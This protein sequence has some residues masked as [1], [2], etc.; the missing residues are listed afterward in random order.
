[1]TVIVIITNLMTMD[2]L[3]DFALEP[4]HILTHHFLLLLPLFNIIY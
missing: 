1:M 3:L 2:I 4:N